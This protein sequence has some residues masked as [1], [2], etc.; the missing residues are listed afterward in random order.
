MMRSREALG[1][2]D[3]RVK[4]LPAFS[5]LRSLARAVVTKFHRPGD[6][7][8]NELILAHHCRVTLFPYAVPL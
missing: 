8:Q 2:Q 3:L 6:F 4:M 7:V 5:G 1:C